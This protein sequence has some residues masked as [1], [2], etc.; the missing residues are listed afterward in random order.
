[1]AM[2]NRQVTGALLAVAV[3]A[4]EFTRRGGCRGFSPRRQRTLFVRWIYR[5]F[6]VSS[7]NWK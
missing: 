2:K 6:A 5:E 1:M 4:P 7:E 3:A